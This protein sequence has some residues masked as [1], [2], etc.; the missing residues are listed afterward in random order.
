MMDSH[1][2]IPQAFWVASFVFIVGKIAFRST[3]IGLTGAGLVVAALLDFSSATRTIFSAWNHM[4][5][6]QASTH[7]NVFLAIGIEA[8]FAAFIA[9]DILQEGKN[10]MHITRTPKNKAA[11]IGLFVF[12]IVFM[13]TI[14]TTSFR[15]W[16]GIP[17]FSFGINTN[18]PTLIL[19]YAGMILYLNHF[20]PQKRDFAGLSP[21]AF[22]RLSATSDS[23]EN[24]LPL[25]FGRMGLLALVVFYLTPI[26]QG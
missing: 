20:V 23:G 8:V 9:V 16:L 17:E 12:G 13:C 10:A 26:S 11:I 15:Q 7:Q 6:V 21:D 5:L 22:K 2:L 24:T 25:E 1:D 18:V 19:T 14:A 3:Q 4:N